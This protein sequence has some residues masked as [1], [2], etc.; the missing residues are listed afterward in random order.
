MN[1]MPL[2]H[3]FS[4]RVLKKSGIWMS[5]SKELLKMPAFNLFFVE[6]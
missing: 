4:R 6:G 1:V 2:S 3:A 5:G